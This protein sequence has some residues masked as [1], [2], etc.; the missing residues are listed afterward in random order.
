MFWMSGVLDPRMK[1]RFIGFVGLMSL[2]LVGYVGA[3]VTGA[4]FFSRFM[5]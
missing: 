3:I 5:F 2:F 4:P 1:H